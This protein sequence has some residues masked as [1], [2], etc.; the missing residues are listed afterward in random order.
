MS[1]INDTRTSLDKVREN[2]IT[3]VSCCPNTWLQTC[4]FSLDGDAPGQQDEDD[5]LNFLT[6]LK[7]SG[8]KLQGVFLYGIARTSMQPEAQR[9]KALSFDQMQHFAERIRRLELTVN[10]VE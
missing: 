4:W 6:G 5:Y 10:V 3:A 8:V 7:Q 1:R 9:I 2:L